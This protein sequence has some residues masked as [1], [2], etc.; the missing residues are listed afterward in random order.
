MLSG[1]G[2]TYFQNIENYVKPLM[3]DIVLLEGRNKLLEKQIKQLYRTF[4]R[5]I[6]DLKPCK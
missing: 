5:M 6:T 3:E 4:K 2:M 1:K